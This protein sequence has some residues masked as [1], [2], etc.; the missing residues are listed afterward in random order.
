MNIFKK[1]PSNTKVTFSQGIDFGLYKRYITQ[2]V[3]IL[4]KTSLFKCNM[5]TH[6]YTVYTCIHG[7]LRNNIYCLNNMVYNRIIE[8]S[9]VGAY[10]V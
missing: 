10:R 5:Y 4:L 1:D 7:L 6:A 8:N 9:A 3:D 2:Y